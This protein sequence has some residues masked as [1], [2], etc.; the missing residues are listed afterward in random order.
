MCVVYV[1]DMRIYV[2]TYLYIHM[3][4]YMYRHVYFVYLRLCACVSP[5]SPFLGLSLS[6]CLAACLS[7][8]LSLSLSLCVSGS[9][10]SIEQHDNGNKLSD[11]L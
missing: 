11:A 3:S 2:H 7:V 5:L 10:S 6:V 8:C 1:Y 9:P 4:I